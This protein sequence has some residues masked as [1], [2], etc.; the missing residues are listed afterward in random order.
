MML[1]ICI[2]SILDH[3]TSDEVEKVRNNPWYQKMKVQV[4]CDQ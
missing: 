3:G 4:F 1:L 2:Q